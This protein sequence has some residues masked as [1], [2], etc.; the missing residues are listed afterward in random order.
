MDAKFDQLS[1]DELRRETERNRAQLTATVERLSDRISG[2]VSE[3]KERLSPESIK[4]E[5][6][7][8]F[9]ASGE[10]VF[11]TLQRK[12]SEN[13]LQA[14]AIGAGL[15]LP[16]WG[17][18]KKIPAPI[19]LV[20]A[21]LLLSQKSV[22]VKTQKLMD[23]AAG[24]VS[25]FGERVSEITANLQEEAGKA[26]DRVS[27]ATADAGATLDDVAHVAK[28]KI[29]GVAGSAQSTLANAAADFQDSFQ[30]AAATG[31]DAAARA[32]SNVKHST[33]DLGA[34]SRESI[35]GFVG[36][37]PALVCGIGLAVGALVA[38]S[39]PKSDTENRWFG[40]KSDEVKAKANEAVAAGVERVKKVAEGVADD[41]AAAAANEGLN[42]DGMERAVSNIADQFK[43]V[44]E[45]GVKPAGASR[46]PAARQSF[47]S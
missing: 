38:A 42:A 32:Y 24:H 25:A 34:R 3:T 8:Y 39:F 43:S 47:S 45:A 31:T 17:I 26:V 19:L 1:L 41:V 37:N 33:A 6:K 23:D 22:R 10:E 28:D 20:G 36:Q 27:G 40:N 44:A 18:L 13:P 16:L 12:A 7:T 2:A 15:A 4:Q 21:G 9:R 5:V 46:K 14:A 35:T 29:A 30:K 11:H